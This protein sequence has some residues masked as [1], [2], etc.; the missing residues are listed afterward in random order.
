MEFL[1]EG[2]YF[3]L[4]SATRKGAG[5]GKMNSDKIK[6]HLLDESIA[7][8]V[9]FL[10]DLIPEILHSSNIQGGEPWKLPDPVNYRRSFVFYERFSQFVSRIEARPASE[11]VVFVL[12]KQS[13]IETRLIEPALQR[14]TD[15]NI[16]IGPH[17]DLTEFFGAIYR[18]Q[19][20]CLK[21]LMDAVGHSGGYRKDV[22]SSAAAEGRAGDQAQVGFGIGG[23]SATEQQ[24]QYPHSY[25]LKDWPEMFQVV[26]FNIVI[27]E[28][29]YSAEIV[30]IQVGADNSVYMLAYDA[31]TTRFLEIRLSSCSAETRFLKKL[32][33]VAWVSRQRR[34]FSQMDASGYLDCVFLP[35]TSFSEFLAEVEQLVSDAG[36]SASE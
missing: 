2:R 11:H 6:Q 8:N 19:A 9:K 1:H 33:A 30:K 28:I 22:L 29:S 14:I 4:A 12:I 17:E 26:D 31:P 3:K 35:E 13:E 25:R 5:S 16:K 36:R 20:R 21:S 15:V 32:I 24:E 18:S 23:Q 34:L 7:A 27:K 10:D